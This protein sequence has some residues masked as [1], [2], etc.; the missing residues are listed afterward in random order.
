M[1]S[2][3][4]VAVI[5]FFSLFFAGDSIGDFFLGIESRFCREMDS[6]MRAKN[7]LAKGLVVIMAAA[8]LTAC[9]QTGK[10]Y[11]PKPKKKETAIQATPLKPAKVEA[12]LKKAVKPSKKTLPET[13]ALPAKLPAQTSKQTSSSA[14]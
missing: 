4:G 3:T 6:A 14:S 1:S 2:K 13:H 7:K 12:G 9:G 11:L 5:K 8:A 10:L